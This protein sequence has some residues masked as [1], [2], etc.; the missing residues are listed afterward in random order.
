MKFYTSR[1]SVKHSKHHKV[2]RVE[3]DAAGVLHKI[4]VGLFLF[5][6]CPLQNIHSP[7]HAFP[8]EDGLLSIR[9]A[10]QI[11]TVHKGTDAGWDSCNMVH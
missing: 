4:W 6:A 9:G 5:V 1:T 10:R 3:P 8:P 7:S 2:L 11:V